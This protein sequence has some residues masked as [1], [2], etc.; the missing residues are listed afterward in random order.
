MTVLLQN[1][2]YV[3]CAEGNM[4][5]NGSSLFETNRLFSTTRQRARA[6][7]SAR[8]GAK[9]SHQTQRRLD[10]RPT[11]PF[12]TSDV[13]KLVNLAR[14]KWEILWDQDGNYLQYLRILWKSSQ[15]IVLS[16]LA[17]E[18]KRGEG[19]SPSDVSCLCF[20]SL[21]FLSQG[22]GIQRK[23]WISWG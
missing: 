7:L 8:R 22:K 10:V 20:F 11:L 1:G 2:P 12:A 16:P 13:R 6:R 4:L 14:R 21:R 23:S 17:E 19:P 18:F 3:I 15:L 5:A 9:R